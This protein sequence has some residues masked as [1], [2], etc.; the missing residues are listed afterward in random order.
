M[1]ECTDKVYEL[2]EH[3]IDCLHTSI[4]GQES[5]NIA[6]AGAITDMIKDLSE[7]EKNWWEACEAKSKVESMKS[8]NT[9][10]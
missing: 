10:H 3:M 6:E 9:M 2:C 8:S 4:I 1:K 7:A 5:I